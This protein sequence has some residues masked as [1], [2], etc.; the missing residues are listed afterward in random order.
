[1]NTGQGEEVGLPRVQAPGSRRARA[2]GISRR[3]KEKANRERSSEI[4]AA[5]VAD[6]IEFRLD[7]LHV[8]PFR[9]G[10]EYGGL[11]V[12]ATVSSSGARI[13]VT[14]DVGFGDALKPGAEVIDCPSMLDL[15]AP[16]LRA[17]SICESG[18]GNHRPGVF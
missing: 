8:D 5:G 15:P 4:L 14:V 12:R 13:A 9:E 18:P 3:A 17:F 7:A 11:W 16:R 10:M 1:M 6:G 2:D